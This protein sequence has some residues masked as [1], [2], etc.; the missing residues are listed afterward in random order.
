M[1]KSVKTPI[2]KAVKDAF[3]QPAQV[4]GAHLFVQEGKQFTVTNEVYGEVKEA[5][6]M[7]SKVADRYL[8]MQPAVS[9]AF[10]APACYEAKTPARA[11]LIAMLEE[12]HPL[13]DE[14]SKAEAHILA[15]E[16]KQADPKVIHKAKQDRNYSMLSRDKDITNCFNALKQYYKQGSDGKRAER[17]TKS[18]KDRLMELSTI[19][20]RVKPESDEYTLAYTS[21][22]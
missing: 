12:V 22:F 17:T 9:A 18:V 19:L 16:T 7:Q 5:I 8:K 14:I 20:G 2:T 10:G 15:L 1:A 4:T 21:K 6:G 11:A 3:P 13:A